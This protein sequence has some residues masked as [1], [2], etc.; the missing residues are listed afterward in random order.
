MNTNSRR[1]TCQFTIKCYHD[2]GNKH[3]NRLN[4]YTWLGSIMSVYFNKENNIVE[5]SVL[6]NLSV[7]Q[8]IRYLSKL[9]SQEYNQT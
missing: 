4:V 3:I 1:H 6:P 8:V 9:K 7:N 5:K 2:P